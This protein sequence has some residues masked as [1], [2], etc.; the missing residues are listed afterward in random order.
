[1]KISFWQEDNYLSFETHT[2]KNLFKDAEG[3]DFCCLLPIHIPHSKPDKYIFVKL[4]FSAIRPRNLPIWT[5]TRITSAR[6]EPFTFIIT[7]FCNSIAQRKKILNSIH[8]ID[9]NKIYA[10]TKSLA[11]S[12]FFFLNSIL[13]ESKQIPKN[14]PLYRWIFDLTNCMRNWGI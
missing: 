6:R 11:S 12:C 1:M 7:I 9:N 3:M 2:K 14:H 4:F 10:T 8:K 5:K 13:E